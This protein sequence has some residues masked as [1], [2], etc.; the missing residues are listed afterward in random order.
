MAAIL[1]LWIKVLLLDGNCQIQN[2]HSFMREKALVE[3]NK[4]LS[5]KQKWVKVHA[6]EYL[7]WAGYPEP[8][9]A[10]FLSEEALHSNEPQYRIGIWRVL[11]QSAQNNTDKKKI[12]QKI[13]KAYTDM[14]GVDRLHATETLAKLKQP[15]G[16]LFPKETEIT[17]KTENK[18]LYLYALWAS[19]LSEKGVLI[20][21]QQYF[22]DVMLANDNLT[23][24]KISAFILRQTKP[25]DRTQWNVLLKSSLATNS[26]DDAYVSIL[27]TTLLT[28]PKNVDNETLDL[29]LDGLLKNMDHYNVSQQIEWA[30]AISER[31]NKSDLNRLMNI[32]EDRNTTADYNALADDAADLRAAA[33]YAILKITDREK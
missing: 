17:L 33:A 24:R 10:Q 21:N 27:T 18:N 22:L 11:A 32:L 20:R 25:L 26:S 23:L 5:Q 6:A 14:E 9:Y 8:A 31:G 4:T 3:L 12:F 16:L 15:I 2:N 1:F 28:A 29:I 19:S 30:L 13:Y 7:I